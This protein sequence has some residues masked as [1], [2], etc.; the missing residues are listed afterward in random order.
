MQARKVETRRTTAKELPSIR[1]VR[2]LRPDWSS[3]ASGMDL[4][5][6]RLHSHRIPR[7]KQVA[8]RMLMRRDLDMNGAR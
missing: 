1:A 2:L 8:R 7:V 5:L 6:R 4:F 3:V